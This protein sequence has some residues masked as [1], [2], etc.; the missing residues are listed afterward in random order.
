MFGSHLLS[1]QQMTLVYSLI[2]VSTSTKRGELSNCGQGR[3]ERSKEHKCGERRGPSRSR[4]EAILR[5]PAQARIADKLRAQK[6]PCPEEKQ[7]LAI[8]RIACLPQCSLLAK[9]LSR[10]YHSVGFTLV[11]CDCQ[12]ASCR[13]IGFTAICKNPDTR[14]AS[15]EPVLKLDLLLS[16][17]SQPALNPARNPHVAPKVNSS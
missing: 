13:S 8:S 3:R 17:A 15:I 14:I 11:S 10:R 1:D 4:C 16:A 6:E 12:I 2:K 5:G 7:W 9:H